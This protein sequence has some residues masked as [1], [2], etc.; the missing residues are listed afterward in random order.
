MDRKSTERVYA[1]GNDIDRVDDAPDSADMEEE[2]GCEWPRKVQRHHSTQPNTETVG[3]GFRRNDQEKSRMWLQ[4][5]QQ[6]SRKRRGPAD[7]MYV[8]RHMVE[9]RV[10]VQGSMAL[11][12][13]DLEKAFDTVPREMV[14]ATL[15]GMGVPEAEVRM[16]DGTYEKTT[17]RVMV[18]ECVSEKLEVKIGL[19][20]GSVLSPLVF[21]AVL[22]LI[23]RKSA[24]QDAMADDR[25]P[26]RA[27]ELSE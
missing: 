4:E 26:K 6:G 3:E 1:G 9:K 19:R 15:H 10:E 27:A 5:E 14:M 11:G 16:V 8:L 2:R 17:A 25:L 20:Q 18:G 22:D 12:F 21:I 7:G 23:S 13:V 24:V